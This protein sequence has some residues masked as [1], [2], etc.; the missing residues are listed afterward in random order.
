MKIE[1]ECNGY[2][3]SATDDESRTGWTVATDYLNENVYLSQPDSES[4][5]EQLTAY[6]KAIVKACQEMKQDTKDNRVEL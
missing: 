3:Y 2:T 1:R 6:G 4:D 5:L